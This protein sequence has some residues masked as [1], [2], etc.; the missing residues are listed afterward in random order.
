MKNNKNILLIILLGIAAMIFFF[1][2]KKKKSGSVIVGES[3][4][5]GF[6]TAIKAMPAINQILETF[7][8]PLKTPAGSQLAIKE[9]IKQLV[10]LPVKPL[11]NPETHVLTAT[12]GNGGG[13]ISGAPNIE[14]MPTRVK[15]GWLNTKNPANLNAGLTA[16]I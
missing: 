7:G 3:E 14:T 13:I 12:P 10:E 15:Q 9:E 6:G 5:L 2:K 8:A 1:L 4:S 11:Y 16:R